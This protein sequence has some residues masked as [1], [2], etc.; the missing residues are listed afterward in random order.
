MKHVH[1]NSRRTYN[2][3]NNT[4][5]HRERV[6]LDGYYRHGAMADRQLKDHLGFDDMNDVRPRISDLIRKGLVV[7]L[8]IKHLDSKTNVLVRV[9]RAATV[10]EFMMMNANQKQLN[11]F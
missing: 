5:N 1:E 6:V 4:L 7:E 9:C 3:L 11:F 10:E 2:H 8:P